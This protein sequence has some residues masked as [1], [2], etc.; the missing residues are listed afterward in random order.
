MARNYEL[1]MKQNDT[2]PPVR[3]RIVNDS[4]QKPPDLTGATVT[5][6]LMRIDPDSGDLIVI[7]D[8]PAVV[9]IPA[10]TSGTVRYDWDPGDIPDTGRF[11]GLFHILYA[12][13]TIEHYPE[14]GYI[15]AT[16]EQDGSTP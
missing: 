9:E 3:A 13:G 7:F 1:A 15:W 10:A 6:K 8:K 11:M 5:F 16:I 4:D 2:G 14:E 12:D